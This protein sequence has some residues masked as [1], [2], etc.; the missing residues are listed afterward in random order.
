MTQVAL[1]TRKPQMM[2]EYKD[3]DQKQFLYNL[4]RADY[5]KEWGRTYQK[6]GA[7]AR[8]LAFLLRI[9]P[10][11]G[12]FRSMKY[13]DP[14][15]ETENMYFQSMNETLDH[16]RVQLAGLRKTDNVTLTDFDC[17][18]GEKTRPGEYPRADR[19]YDKLL[20]TLN[21]HQFQQMDASLR[22]ELARYYEQRKPTD[23]DTRA[24]LERFRQATPAAPA[25]IE[26]AEKP[27]D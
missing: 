6:P 10:K 25:K 16:F 23:K 4:S 13:K 18:T 22:A 3:F 7:G 1:A 11:V 27:G 17:D 24:A 8:V 2:R 20:R 14:T 15:P 12:P 5:E 19:T 9:I 21:E 26:A